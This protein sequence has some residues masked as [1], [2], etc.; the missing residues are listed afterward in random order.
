MI[1]TQEIDVTYLTNAC[2]EN[3]G[4]GTI[5]LSEADLCKVGFEQGPGALL[6]YIVEIDGKTYVSA[7]LEIAHKDA[8]WNGDDQDF[9]PLDEA[10]E[11]C[12]KANSFLEARANNGAIVLPLDEGDPGRFVIRVAVPLDMLRDAEHTSQVLTDI[13]G[14]LVD[15]PKELIHQRQTF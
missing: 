7:N 10:K 15:A 5:E 14:E 11:Y 9:M 8:F 12:L 2:G 13:F 6:P 1:N 3:T 4:H